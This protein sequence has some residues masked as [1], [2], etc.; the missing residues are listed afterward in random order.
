MEKQHGGFLIS[1]SNYDKIDGKYIYDLNNENG[2]PKLEPSG[3]SVTIN[4]NYLSYNPI[5]SVKNNQR[6]NYS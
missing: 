2:D 5:K 6:A 4:S 3:N 1:T